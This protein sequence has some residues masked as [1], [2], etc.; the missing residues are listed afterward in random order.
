MACGP[1]EL[2]LERA[3][4]RDPRFGGHQGGV[5]MRRGDKVVPLAVER[6][7]LTFSK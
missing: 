2:S 7:K 5:S 1:F 3:P 6:K 4:S